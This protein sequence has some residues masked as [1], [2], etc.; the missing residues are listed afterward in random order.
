M[1]WGQLSTKEPITSSPDFR[2][3]LNKDSLTRK[4]NRLAKAAQPE[5]QRE[6]ALPHYEWLKECLK[7]VTID[8]AV[9]TWVDEQVRLQTPRRDKLVKRK[10]GHKLLKN[11]VFTHG[12]AR[13]YKNMVLEFNLSQ[14][15]GTPE[16]A[17]SIT[18]GRLNTQLT[19]QFKQVWEHLL[20]DGKPLAFKGL[21]L[22]ASQVYLLLSRLSATD[23]GKVGGAD[24]EEFGRM[25][26]S[27]KFYEKLANSL[28]AAGLELNVKEDYKTAFFQ[29]VLFSRKHREIGFRKVF[30]QVYPT[31]NSA[32]MELVTDWVC[33]EE[34]GE[35]T[36]TYKNLAVMLQQQESDLLLN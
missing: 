29:H 21:D 31:V 16:F 10:G 3:K 23:A 18:N 8:P 33:D 2:A 36:P 11:R 9:F 27:G 6:D 5:V 26:V 28:R 25:V 22:S 7:R 20:V 4:R 17:F 35:M 24:L 32:L 19:R 1:F 15:Q 12:L 13:F 14:A 34:T 30:N